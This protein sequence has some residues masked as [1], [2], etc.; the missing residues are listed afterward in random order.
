[1]L[2]YFVTDSTAFGYGAVDIFNIPLGHCTTKWDSRR[3]SDQVQ[4]RGLE[5]IP[6]PHEVNS[7]GLDP[8][9]RPVTCPAYEEPDF[10]PFSGMLQDW[11]QLYPRE[12][13]QFLQAESASSH[14]HSF[15][16]AECLNVLSSTRAEF[17]GYTGHYP[18]VIPRRCLVGILQFIRNIVIRQT[19][20]IPLTVG[21]S[22]CND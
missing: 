1:M 17:T 14:N 20:N 12:N 22:F 19:V 5:I 4:D 6:D 7:L 11:C 8:Y 18:S 2:L 13:A 21:L 3:D 16:S 10:M 15:P 9:S